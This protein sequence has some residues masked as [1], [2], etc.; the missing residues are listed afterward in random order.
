M[1]VVEERDI[2]HGIGHPALLPNKDRHGQPGHGKEG[3][4]QR[5][6]KAQLLAY[7]EGQGEAN[8]PSPNPS[9]EPIEGFTPGFGR[10]GRCIIYHPSIQNFECAKFH[11][12]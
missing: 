1:R 7:G 9:P 8:S 2:D 3:H 11:S 12:N 5:G 10:Q 6:R 4:D